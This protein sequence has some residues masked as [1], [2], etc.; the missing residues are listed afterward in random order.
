[1]RY[2][3]GLLVRNTIEESGSKDLPLERVPLNVTSPLRNVL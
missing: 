2:L 3:P 1:M